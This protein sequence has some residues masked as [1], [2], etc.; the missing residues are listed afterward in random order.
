MH[1]NSL[2]PRA[3]HMINQGLVSLNLEF[4]T[5]IDYVSGGT[6]LKR[7]KEISQYMIEEAD[8]IFAGDDVDN[9]VIK[10]YDLPMR[11]V[12]WYDFRDQTDIRQINPALYFK[13][14]VYSS[15]IKLSDNRV[16]HLDFCCLDEYF[17]NDT[18][19]DISIGCYF[20]KETASSKRL[21]LIK[22]LERHN[23]EGA[24]IGFTTTTSGKTGRASIRD[25]N[26]PFHEYIQ[27]LHR[28][29]IIFT[30][31]NE[32]YRGDNRVWEAFASGALVFCDLAKINNNLPIENLHFYHFDSTDKNDVERA[33]EK[34]KE[35]L[36]N[37]M[38]AND[39]VS[40]VKQNHMSKNR[41][42]YMLKLWKLQNIL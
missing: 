20:N 11:K 37:N 10:K 32:A 34:A 1:L 28:T 3:S 13:R 38:Y 18:V 31:D 39:C 9:Y 2:G 22:A 15:N 14:S 33:I 36:K 42:E 40:F 12:I 17:S 19:R 21:L 30:T 41:V 27:L 26:S 4:L 16:H 23:I 24:K 7:K 35:L 25:N 29:K 8:V 6:I 5:D